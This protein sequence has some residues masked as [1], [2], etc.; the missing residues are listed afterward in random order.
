MHPSAMKNCE[1]FFHA[2]YR[3]PD[4]QK[5]MTIVE[6]GSQN[7]NGSLRSV[8]PE[9]CE[10]IG[11]DFVNGNGVDVILEDPYS[12]PFADGVAD[13]VLASSVFE[14]SSFFWILYLEIMRIVKP[15]GLFYLNVPSNGPFHRYPVDCWR[16]YPDSGKALSEWACRNGMDVRLLESFVSEQE[17][18]VW[19]DFVAVFL[20]DSSYA[21]RYADRIMN[22]KDD[23][24]N[25]SLGSKDEFLKPIDLPQDQ[26]KLQV[27]TNIIN[28]TVK[29]V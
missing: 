6:I 17:G 14:H 3:G 23:Y 22:Y 27:I 2:Y 4:H 13:V 25:G 12:L 7:V 21:D 1:Y 8:A 29:I 20:K 10:Y 5:P 11:V 24:K 15:G 18:D 26:L 16:F 19:N 28:N 9:G